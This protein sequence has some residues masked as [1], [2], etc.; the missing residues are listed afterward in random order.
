MFASRF[1]ILRTAAL[2]AAALALSGTPAFAGGGGHG[3]GGGGGHGGGGGGG[4]GGGGGGHGGGGGGHGGG[5]GGHGGGGGGHG[6]GGFHSGGFSRGGFGYYPGFGIGVGGYG[7][8]Y[9]GGYSDGYYCSEPAPIY[10]QSTPVVIQSQ[11]FYPSD[12]ALT[13]PPAASG[14]AATVTLRVPADADVWFNGDPT[15]QRGESRQ[16]ASPPLSPGRDYHYE[17]R[18]RWTEGDR[19][20]DQTRRVTVRADGRTDVDFTRP[21]PVGAPSPSK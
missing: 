1:Y 6:G 7:G 15:T 12:D 18:A 16:F 10:V 14:G 2:A 5:G 4:H 21:E 17:V 13:P 3:G 8:G 11:R 9:Y 20:V 19:I